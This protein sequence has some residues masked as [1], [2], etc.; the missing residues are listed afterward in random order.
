MRHAIRLTSPCPDA[1]F[2]LA[3]EERERHC[4]TC[5][6]T[7]VN[8]SALSADEADRVVSGGA[9]ICAQFRRGR[10]GAV[11]HLAA[12]ALVGLAAC[13]PTHHRADV[14]VA[15][16]SCRQDVRVEAA[17]GAAGDVTVTVVDDTDLSIPGALVTGTGPSGVVFQATTDDDGHAVFHNIPA[18]RWTWLIQMQGF[19]GVSV[20]TTLDGT[21]AKIITRLDYGAVTVGGVFTEAH[22]IDTTSASSPTTLDAATLSRLP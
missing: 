2:R 15:P 1:T 10:D 6:R 11:L 18:G 14:Q 3:D 4:A 20:A 9:R 5:D 21:A 19:G 16:A 12:A 13:A 7:V 17:P 22:A 8:L